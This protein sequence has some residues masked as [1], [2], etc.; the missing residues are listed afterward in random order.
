M[1][2]LLHVLEA[3]H[4]AECPLC[5]TAPKAPG[6]RRRLWRLGWLWVRR[7]VA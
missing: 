2:A 3:K 6:R 4:R 7:A 5:E 1:Q